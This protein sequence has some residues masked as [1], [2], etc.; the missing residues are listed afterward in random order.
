MAIS[1]LILRNDSETF[2]F[3]AYDPPYGGGKCYLPN[4][5]QDL[6]EGTKVPGDG[7]YFNLMTETLSFD[8]T[9]GIG[10]IKCVED[11][12]FKGW[13]GQNSDGDIIE[14]SRRING[15]VKKTKV[16]VAHLESEESYP[17]LKY[18]EGYDEINGYKWDGE[19]EAYCYWESVGGGG[20]KWF[21]LGDNEGE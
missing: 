18:I 10:H 13:F 17:T 11:G 5:D 3:L 7:W 15:N 19:Y 20:G 2:S 1:V 6:V 21:F 12:I 8:P 14:K 4:Y 16:T 9:S